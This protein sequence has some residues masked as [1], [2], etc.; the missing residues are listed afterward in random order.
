MP[1]GWRCW[2]LCTVAIHRERFTK[3]RALWLFQQLLL[4]HAKGKEEKW[5]K[6]KK[7][8]EREKQERNR[9]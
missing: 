3:D 7:E 8:E 6:E 4:Q 1:S 2:V 5:E 9:T